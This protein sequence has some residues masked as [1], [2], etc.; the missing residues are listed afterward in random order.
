M[1]KNVLTSKFI[2]VDYEGDRLFSEKIGLPNV[3]G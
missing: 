3:G 2:V 1:Q